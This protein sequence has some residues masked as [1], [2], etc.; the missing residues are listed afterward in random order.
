MNR[1]EVD[2]RVVDEGDDGSC[3]GACQL[4]QSRCLSFLKQSRQEGLRLSFM[5]RW[6]GRRESVRGNIQGNEEMS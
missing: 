5:E 3:R 1:D 6:D 2:A 4:V